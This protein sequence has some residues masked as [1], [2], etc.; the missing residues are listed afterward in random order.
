MDLL[1]GSLRHGEARASAPSCTVWQHRSTLGVPANDRLGFW[2]QFPGGDHIVQPLGSTGDFFGE[3]R[4]ALT[5][6]GIGYAELA[7]DPCVSR[8][9]TNETDMLQ[10]GLVTAGV[11]RIQHGRDERFVLYSGGEPVLFDGGRPL[12]TISTRIKLSYLRLSRAAVVAALGEDAVPRGMAIRCLPPGV[13][14][15]QLTAC[16]RGLQ[17]E[18]T[19]DAMTVASAVRTARA[20]ALVNLANVRGA[21][22]H[23]PGTLDAALYCAACHQLALRVAQP[24]VTAAAVAA[25][26]GC[27]RAQLYRVFAARDDTIAGHLQQLRMQRATALLGAR[28]QLVIGTIALRC[29]YA[30]PAAFAKA[31][32]RRF[33]MTPTDWRARMTATV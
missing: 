12:T 21:G 8:F 4:T 20:L 33:G 22:H 18:R 23:W 30:E 31:F 15:S 19:G 24:C 1:E 32:R 5:P 26:L 3:F 17:H 13:L 25:V 6:A 9:G 16:L 10:L 2:R 28:P 27:S 7:V 14:T 11:M 29:G